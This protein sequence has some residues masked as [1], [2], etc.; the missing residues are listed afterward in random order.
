MAKSSKPVT[1]CKICGGSIQRRWSLGNP[2]RE[3]WQHVDE[4]DWIDNPHEPVA[5]TA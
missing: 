1:K 5:A 4:D 3:P 2:E